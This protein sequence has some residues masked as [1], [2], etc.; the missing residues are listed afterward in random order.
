MS[1]LDPL[2]IGCL[3][4]RC[5]LA[6]EGK[7]RHRPVWSSPVRT[8]QGVLIG[9]GPGPD[10]VS[11]GRPFTGPVG[12]E[13]DNSLFRAGLDKSRLL[14]MNAVLCKPPFDKTDGMMRKA[15]KCCEPAFSWQL[16][17][18]SLTTPALVMGKAAWEAT[19]GKLPKGGVE[20]GRGFLRSHNGRPY[21][22]TWTPQYAFF[23][24]P[25]VWGDFDVDVRRWKRMLTGKLRK[26]PEL[27]THAK[28][29]DLQEL[30]ASPLPISIDIESMPVGQD[31]PWTGLDATRAAIRTV[32]LG[33][34][35]LGV[36]FMWKDA[37]AEHLLLLKKAMETRLTVWQNGFWFDLRVF[38]RY[39]FKALF[40]EDTRDARRALSATSGLS[41]RYLASIYDDC[42]PWKEDS[43]DDT[44]NLY[45][46]D[47]LYQ[48]M[49][50]NAQD[51]VE[52]ARTW[53]G[54]IG[55]ASWLEPRVQSLYAMNKKLSIIA[56]RMNT[57]GVDVHSWNRAVLA[58]GLKDEYKKRVRR[59]RRK[60]GIRGFAANAQALRKLLFKRHETEG[61][62][63]FSL[64]DPQNPKLWASERTISVDQGALLMHLAD[65]DF[66]PEAAKIVELYWEADQ[67]RKAR[68]TYIVSEMVERAIRPNGRLGAGW[69]SLG[70]DTGRPSCSQPNLL[71]LSEKKE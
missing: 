1:V 48:L 7:P 53:E 24:N 68:S 28:P 64:P 11:S 26:A 17:Q 2:S 66:P 51:T 39:G 56:A 12:A 45:F 9:E 41:L 22:A 49:L 59:L 50:Y 60:V 70:T 38:A 65:P 36:S 15:V 19:V 43:S 69:N 25:F 37:T 3:C 40:P 34:V 46:G 5:P 54:E 57:T 20:E 52:Q 10:E 27:R 31:Q 33:N 18:A 13:L 6:K 14:L 44:K 47:D 30:L 4:D 42:Q 21:I 55:E 67:V 62:R 61:V 63:M 8:P 29:S 16:N 71:N 35:R 32:G 58:M 23:F